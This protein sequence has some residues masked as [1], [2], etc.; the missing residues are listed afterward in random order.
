MKVRHKGSGIEGTSSEFNIHTAAPQEIIVSYSNDQDSDY[1]RDF[2]VQISGEWVD[3]ADAFRTNRLITDNYNT[4][5]F[6]PATEEDRV[7]GYTL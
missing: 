2:D 6:E 4:R 1:L 5:F 7:M 3:M